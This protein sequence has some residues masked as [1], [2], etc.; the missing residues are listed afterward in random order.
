MFL[1]LRNRS[2]IPVMILIRHAINEWDIKVYNQTELKH[3][4]VLNYVNS[5]INQYKCFVSYKHS[6][7]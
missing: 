7:N 3:Q 5:A 2:V 6:V 1:L 4:P